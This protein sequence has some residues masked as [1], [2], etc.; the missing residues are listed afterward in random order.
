M[1][2][3]WSVACSAIQELVLGAGC[4]QVIMTANITLCEEAS[5]VLRARML[6]KQ[7]HS[8]DKTTAIKLHLFFTTSLV[9]SS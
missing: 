2:A 6:S 9:Q 8:A 4:I 5:V 7:P 3:T 1:H